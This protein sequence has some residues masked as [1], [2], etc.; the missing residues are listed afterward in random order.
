VQGLDA[1]HA[2]HCR[3]ATRDAGVPLSR[4]DADHAPLWTDFVRQHHGDDALMRADV[5]DAA[6]GIE[7][8]ADQQFEFLHARMVAFNA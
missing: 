7:A 1:G 6:A 2:V 8:A 3:V 5:E 4:L